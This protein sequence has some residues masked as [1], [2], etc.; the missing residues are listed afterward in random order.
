MRATKAFKAGG[1]R[2]AICIELNPPQEI[3]NIPTLP[4]DQF[5]LA[6]Q[7]MTESQSFSSISEYS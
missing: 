1:L 5:C 2:T 4:L 7:A 3:P 6:N